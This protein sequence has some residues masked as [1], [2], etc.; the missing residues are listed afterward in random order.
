MDQD[1]IAK[2]YS[3]LR[4]ES[5]ATG[6]LPI[7]VRHIESVI[8]MSE[9]HARMHLREAVQEVDVNMAI[10]MMLESFIEAQKFSVT[11]KMKS[12]FQKYL[13]FQKDHSELLYFILRQ[14]TLEQLAYI[15]CKEG[16]SATHVEVMEKDLTER[17]KSINIFNFKDFYDSEVFKKYGYTYDSKRKIILQ[18]VPEAAV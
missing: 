8:R 4:Q 3:Q 6:S 13:S 9:A 15:R 18:V 11:K 5:L 10:R 7:T 16:P 17:A 1:K 12:T 14:L 2:M